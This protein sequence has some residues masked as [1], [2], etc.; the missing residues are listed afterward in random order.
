MGPFGHH[1]TTVVPPQHRGSRLQTLRPRCSESSAMSDLLRRPGWLPGLADVI[2]SSLPVPI[3]LPA[4]PRSASAARSLLRSA[5][6][7]HLHRAVMDDVELLVT[8]L[9]ANASATESEQCIVSVSVPE[10]GVVRIA[11]ADTG[12]EPPAVG[13]ANSLAENGR[14]LKI[15]DHLALRWGVEAATPAGKTVWFEVAAEAVA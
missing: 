10:A 15:I 7:L 1:S 14:G 11:V 13:T 2:H 4:T 5:L 12:H 3:T 9:V 6:Q 8:E